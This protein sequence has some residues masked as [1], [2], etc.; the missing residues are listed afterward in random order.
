[1]AID[2]I[3]KKGY[4]HFESRKIRWGRYMKAQVFPSVRKA[5][6]ALS[7][8]GSQYKC[9][10]LTKHEL[11]KLRKLINKLLEHEDLQ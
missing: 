4:K 10:T 9:I 5:E 8:D 6:I 11:L 3:S 7:H 2:I 1:M